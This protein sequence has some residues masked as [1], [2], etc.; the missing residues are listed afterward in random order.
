MILDTSEKTLA[1]NGGLIS[2]RPNPNNGVFEISVQSAITEDATLSITD[3]TGRSLYET[4]CRTN[5]PVKITTQLPSGVYFAVV[6][7]AH[8]RKT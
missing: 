8:G 7:T 1:P 6:N 5:Q 4:Y 2:I 3:L